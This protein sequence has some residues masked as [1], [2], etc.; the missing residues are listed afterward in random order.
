LNCDSPI[1]SAST[2]ALEGLPA[3]E[4]SPLPFSSC[5]SKQMKRNIL[6]YMFPRRQVNSAV[7]LPTLT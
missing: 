1:I 4:T 7:L 2:F 3:L 6:I 5:P